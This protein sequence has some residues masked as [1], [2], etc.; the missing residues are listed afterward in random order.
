MNNTRRLL[1]CTSILVAL[2][3]CNGGGS[4]GSSGSGEMNF[5]APPD[6]TAPGGGAGADGP[7]RFSGTPTLGAPAP[8]SSFETPEYNFG[9]FLDRINAAARYAQGA[10]GKGVLVG[11]L[12]TGVQM[13]NPEL[14][15]AVI[16][17][18]SYDYA[19]DTATSYDHGRHGT[20]M[21][22]AIGARRDGT[23]MHGVAPDV[24]IASYSAI[25]DD[26]G[27]W[28]SV[29]AVADAYDRLTNAGG[30]G[31][32]ASYSIAIE[33]ETMT[34]ANTSRGQI[35]M[36]YGRA[37]QSMRRASSQGVLSAFSTGNH[38]GTN[39]SVLAGLPKYF[40]ELEDTWLAVTA[41]DEQDRLADFA[42]ACGDAANWCVAAPGTGIILPNPGGGYSSVNGTSP[43]N[44]I[45]MGALALL[46][47]NFPELTSRD[48]RLIL[49][50]TARDLG[51]PGVDPV[52]GH[53]AIDLENAMAPQGTVNIQGGFELGEK[54]WRA[55]DSYVSG[56][57]AVTT[58]LSQALEGSTVGVT[59][60]YGRGYTMSAPVTLSDR[61]ED[62]M[63]DFKA[64]SLA[65]GDLQNGFDRL[66]L[67]ETPVFFAATSDGKKHLAA[68]VKNS[69]E[70]NSVKF[71]G[72]FETGLGQFAI[73]AGEIRESDALLGASLS[74]AYAADTHTRFVELDWSRDLGGVAK[75][76][77]HLG[78]GSSKLESHAL[79]SSHKQLH[80]STMAVRY[81]KDLSDE[82]SVMFG[83]SS[84]LSL[85]S[86]TL[87][88]DRPTGVVAATSTGRGTSVTRQVERYEIE[89]ATRD[90]DL[91]FGFGG[92]LDFLGHDG[93]YG[94]GLVADL[95]DPSEAHAISMNWSL[96]F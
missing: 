33:N 39:V 24:S 49:L 35:N 1:L 28:T 51:A 50:E 46:Q 58:A 26:L 86:G 29:N 67:G 34:T 2:S 79:L 84:P 4:G 47:S 89:N 85:Q 25:A 64:I 9:R 30:F 90:Y 27:R 65:N 78:M 71:T 74:G 61:S 68:S 32:S 96:K 8:R 72:S 40:P 44:A 7:R 45:G 76:D 59:D 69:I 52:F 22:A 54:T 38:G 60:K 43:A 36:F 56:V 18:F 91:E 95:R 16:E 10:S 62:P 14:S 13:N 11:V 5:N 23:G 81:S 83:I 21:A 57:G 92:D 20:W 31:M 12:D 42:A 15:G 63:I 48:V 17:E 53:G 94:I 82:H 87:E 55:Q 88:M 93:R 37:I 6:M 77:M 66:S 70:G 73:S 19:T 80:S 41:L 75:L 3:A